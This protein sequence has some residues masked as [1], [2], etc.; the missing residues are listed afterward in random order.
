MP[1]TNTFGLTP[2]LYEHV[3]ASEHLMCKPYLDPVGLPTIGYGHRVASMDHPPITAAEAVVM[4]GDD[5]ARF[6]DMALRLSPGLKDEP[7]RRCAAIVDFCFNAGGNAYA[8]SVLRLRVNEKKWPEA[9]EQMRR[10]VYGTV[11]GEKV[12]L[13]GLVKRRAATA[14]WLEEV[15]TTP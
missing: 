10:W 3:K 2:E 4:L 6:R 11:Q 14:K 5:L 1:P 13:P 12:V 8:K 7:E 15:S 9:A